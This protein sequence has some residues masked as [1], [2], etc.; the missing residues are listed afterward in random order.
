M[1]V[2]IPG[3]IERQE[4]DLIVVGA[5]VNGAAIARDAAIR[6]LRTLLL[7]KGDIASGTTSW[8]SRL[9]HGGLRYLEHGEVR[10]VRESLRE[11]ER[12]L[13]N[14]PHLVGPLPMVIPMYDGNRRRPSVIRA[15][16]LAYDALSLDKSLPRHRVWST[17]E[18]LRRVP[19][20]NPRGLR[21]AALY[22]DAQATFAER[23]AVENVISAAE[24]GATVATY[25]RVNRLIQDGNRVRG[26]IAADSLEGV[27]FHVSGRVVV[28]ISGPWVDHVLAGIGEATP[29]LIGG[30]KGSHLVVD[31]FPGAP[32]TA[33][34]YEAHDHRVVLVIPWNGRYLIGTTD[35]RYEGDLDDVRT[36]EGEVEYLLNE[37]NQV[38]PGANLTRDHVRYA[39]AGIRPLP[40]QPTG[41]EAEISRDHAVVD[42]APT[43]RG[44]L[45]ITGGKLTTFRALAEHTVDAVYRQLGKTPPRCETTRLPLPGAA[46]VSLPS[47]RKSLIDQS[48]LPA[49]SVERLVS[50]YGARAPDVLAVADRDPS[51]REPFYAGTGSIGAEV[52]FAVEREFARTLEDVMMR[53][54]MVGL[55]PGHGIGAD[56]AAA[57]IGRR[58]LGW[59]EARAR[60]EVRRYREYVERFVPR[61]SDPAL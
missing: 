11:R 60:D 57:A 15:G 35:I 32:S 61:V 27:D 17:R 47:F 6:G 36:E 10:L 21:G 50:I 19:G 16:M 42:H 24:H 25:C 34:Y 1:G 59:D 20:L 14:A 46:G 12:L 7:D 38:I 18:A 5:G 55:E 44:L 37:T 2:T 52:L 23:L 30:T 31:P 58:H 28:N 9:I 4:F 8:S 3:D 43:I 13:R 54:T 51:L 49:K 40:Y 29:R 26:V 22:Y 41:S 45:S 33:L 48:G 53:R 56:E 39:Y